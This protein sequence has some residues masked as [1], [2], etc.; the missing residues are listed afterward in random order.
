MTEY[1]GKVTVNMDLHIVSDWKLCR[2]EAVLDRGHADNIQAAGRATVRY[3][4]DHER[5]LADA[6]WSDF[7]FFPTWDLAFG[8][9]LNDVSLRVEQLANEYHRHSRVRLTEEAATRRRPGKE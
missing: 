3:S 8:R 6:S 9:F 4:P 1:N 2:A 7:H 5:Y